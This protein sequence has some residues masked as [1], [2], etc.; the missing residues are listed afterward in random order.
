MMNYC[1]V[2]N[3][4]TILHEVVKL[5]I[6]IYIFFFLI[7]LAK[8]ASPTAGSEFS[9]PST[10]STRLP[11]G[12]SLTQ[13]ELVKPDTAGFDPGTFVSTLRGNT[14]SA[15]TS[16]NNTSITRNNTQ[17][18]KFADTILERSITASSDSPSEHSSLAKKPKLGP[19]DLKARLYDRPENNQAIAVVRQQQA[20]KKSSD[21]KKHEVMLPLY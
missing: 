7:R 19:L 6:L 12:T 9:R 11:E 17:G 13:A 20:A 1:D 16:R 8:M 14:I 10:Y 4:H 2:Y 18:V 15:N 5:L 3:F 21:T